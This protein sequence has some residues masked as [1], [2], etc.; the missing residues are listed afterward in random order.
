MRDQDEDNEAGF[1]RMNSF[2]GNAK[3]IYDEEH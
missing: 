1:G 3:D 2:K